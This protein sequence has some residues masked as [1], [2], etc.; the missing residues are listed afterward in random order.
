[1]SRIV[2]LDVDGPLITD[3]CVAV[4]PFASHNRSKVSTTALYWVEALCRKTGALVVMNSTHND[5]LVD[6]RRTLRDDMVCFGFPLELFHE[7]WRTSF[8]LESLRDRSVSNARALGVESWLADYPEYRDQWVC[9]DDVRFTSSP[10]LVL[11]DEADG[12]SSRHYAKALKLF[13]Y[14]NQTR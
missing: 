12:I 7:S 2:F 13:G 8:G 5:Y 9:F 6:E 11:V 14:R 4:D 3:A 10:R 1:M